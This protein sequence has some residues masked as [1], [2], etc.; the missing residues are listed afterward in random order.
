MHDTD[1]AAL[2][3][4]H[5]GTGAFGPLLRRELVAAA[6]ALINGARAPSQLTARAGE[7][8]RN[9]FHGAAADRRRHGHRWGSH[10]SLVGFECKVLVG[11]SQLPVRCTVSTMTTAVQSYS[12]DSG[13]MLG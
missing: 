11:Q 1:P 8:R 12:S 4:R 2:G 5:I 13:Q 6:G 9:G 10:A 3:F 7:V